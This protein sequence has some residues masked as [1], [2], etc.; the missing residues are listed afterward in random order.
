MKLCRKNKT[1]S[2]KNE[3]P[4]KK[5]SKKPC[6][7][8]KP[9]KQQQ[10]QLKLQ[11]EAEQKLKHKEEARL[12]L[13]QKQRQKLLEEERKLAEQKRITAELKLQKEE[14]GFK[15]KNYKNCLNMLGK[16]KLLLNKSSETDYLV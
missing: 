13:E 9:Y 12:Q 16:G 6:K 1:S 14:K 15:E 8:P 7:R 2:Y 3:K 5:L 10:L 11:L 4:L